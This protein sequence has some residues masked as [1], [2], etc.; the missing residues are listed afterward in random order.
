[1]AA[2]AMFN[3]IRSRNSCQTLRALTTFINIPDLVLTSLIVPD[4]IR[5]S[6]LT[7][8]EIWANAQRDGRPA[9]YWRRPLFNAA[10]FGRRLTRA[11][12]SN[13]AK[14]RN[15]SKFAGCPKLANGSQPLCAEVRHIVRTLSGY[16]FATKACIDNRKNNL[17]SSNMSSTCSHNMVNFGTL[18]T[19]VDP[20]VW[21]TPANCNGFRVL[22]ALL[23]GS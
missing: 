13:A 23:N 16:I 1:M 15:P 3:C 14:T 6:F 7:Q 12:S 10:K 19:E 11:P 2:D 9:E 18:A 4:G 17:L 21:G 22:A 20:V 5:M 8:L